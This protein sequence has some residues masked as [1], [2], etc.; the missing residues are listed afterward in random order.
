[1]PQP[2]G[3]PLKGSTS[4]SSFSVCAGSVST[5]VGLCSSSETAETGGTTRLACGSSNPVQSYRLSW[6]NYTDG[7]V[8]SDHSRR[9][10]VNVI[11]ASAARV[12]AKEEETHTDSD[13]DLY[14]GAIE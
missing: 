12:F 4:G 7:R 5:G 8:V 6:D 11:M 3:A 9:Y 2:P 14:S 13:D 10:I 1:M